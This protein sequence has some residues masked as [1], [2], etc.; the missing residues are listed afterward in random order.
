MTFPPILELTVTGLHD[1]G[2]ANRERIQ[3][4]VDMDVRL[5]GFCIVHGTWIDGSTTLHPSGSHFFQFPDVE[6][7]AGSW[8]FIYTGPGETR[9][10]RLS[11]TLQP[12]LAL[13]WGCSE[14]IFGE[15]NESFAILR[16]GGVE[17]GPK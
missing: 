14:T 9:S 16:I 15:P 4:R 10:T 13:H 11:G 7:K 8:I 5:A 2:V 6:A 3:I 17:F 12:A 1:R